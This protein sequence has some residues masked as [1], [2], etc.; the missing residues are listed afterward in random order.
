MGKSARIRGGI[1]LI[2][3]LLIV[4][5]T[6]GIRLECSILKGPS[7]IITHN[8]FKILIGIGNCLEFK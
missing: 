6:P 2:D 1:L 4:L 3:N 7:L 5:Y 8:V